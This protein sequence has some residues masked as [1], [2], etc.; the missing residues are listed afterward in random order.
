M[1]FFNS[2]AY[3]LVKYYT[4][5]LLII[6]I[7]YI[8]LFQFFMGHLFWEQGK[9][10]VKFLALFNSILSPSSL[11]AWFWQ[12]KAS[13]RNGRG[14]ILTS[15]CTQPDM[16]GQKEPTT[17]GCFFLDLCCFPDLR[18]EASGPKGSPHPIP[19]SLETTRLFLVIINKY[20]L[21]GSPW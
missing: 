12:E 15:C 19:F 17:R 1:C 16:P 20:L 6:V 13:T 11:G 2:N 8:E 5:S 18:G 3:F 4:E 7:K 10:G 9:R 14:A 21:F